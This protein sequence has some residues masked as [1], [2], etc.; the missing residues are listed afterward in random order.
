MANDRTGSAWECTSSILHMDGGLVT[1]HIVGTG[2]V[3]FMV[4][5]WRA[6]FLSFFCLCFFEAFCLFLVSDD[7]VVVWSSTTVLSLTTVMPVLAWNTS[8]AVT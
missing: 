2:T 8:T 5:E 6:F 4:H 1:C 3:Y 7:F